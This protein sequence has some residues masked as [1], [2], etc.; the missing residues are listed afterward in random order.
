M[1]L[2]GH[3]D[4]TTGAAWVVG[5]RT[6]WSRRNPSAF[7][8]HAIVYVGQSNEMKWCCSQ[9]WVPERSYIFRIMPLCAVS[10]LYVSSPCACMSGASARFVAVSLSS[11]L[12][13]QRCKISAILGL[14][15]LPPFPFVRSSCHPNQISP[16]STRAFFSLPQ[17]PLATSTG[18]CHPFNASRV[19]HPFQSDFHSTDGFRRV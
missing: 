17:C 9:K 7:A 2:P 8:R 1:G 6:F 14:T 11:L 13:I 15:P 4:G 19:I 3:R 18:C 5:K 12:Q 16:C 10:V